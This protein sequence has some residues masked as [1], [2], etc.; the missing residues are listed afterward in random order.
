MRTFGVEEELLLVDVRTGLPTAAAPRILEWRSKDGGPELEAEIQQEMIEVVGPVCSTTQQLAGAIADGRRRADADAVAVGA[1]A[2]PLATSPVSVHPHASP[3]SRYAEMMRRYGITA[4][5][6][7]TCGFHVHVA[8]DSP[9]EGVAALDRIRDWLPTILALS[10]NSPFWDG[11]DTGY[12][13]YRNDVWSRWPCAGPN[14]VFGSEAAYREH[15]GS[16]LASGALLDE[17]M[18][19]FDARLSRHH[20]TLEVRVADICL[21]QEDAVTIAALCRGL[22]ETAVIEWQAGM[23]PLRTDQRLLGLAT[24]RAALSG[25]RGDHVHPVAGTPCAPAA[26]IAALLEHVRPGLE[27]LG[28]VERVVHG[29]Q[30]ILR[31]GTGADWQREQVARRGS[32]GDIVRNLSADGVPAAESTGESASVIV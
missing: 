27:A 18:L 5:R 17:G 3:S 10:S 13:S 12:A 1:R 8:I 25:M 24:W 11:T 6:T 15:E 9:R 32:V 21:R 14:P 4:R 16:L 30:E 20:P 23:P 26:S 31:R 29:V 7:L 28:D 2:L 19:Y 22:V